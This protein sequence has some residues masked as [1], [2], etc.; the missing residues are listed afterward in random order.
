MKAYYFKHLLKFKIPGGTSRGVLNDKESWFI[1][2]INGENYGIGE[3]S[4][5]KGLSPDPDSTFELK[6]KDICRKIHLGFS[7]LSLEL[8]SYPAI[9]FGL[10]T[11]FRS[12]ES[13]NP[14]VFSK[15]NFTTGEGS[16]SINGLIW[17][18]KKS[19]S[20][21]QK[22]VFELRGQGTC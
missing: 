3:C 6:L 17:M 5:I 13:K 4:L 1:I 8:E 20:N 22:N 19:Y 18:G 14:F 2:I 9:L 15:S 16:L 10:E 11:A 12:F 21:C 7:N